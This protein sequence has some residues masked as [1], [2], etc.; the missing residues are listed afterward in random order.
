MIQKLIKSWWL[1]A[2]GILNA[3]LR[4]HTRDLIRQF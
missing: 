2:C 3:T 1:L 4:L